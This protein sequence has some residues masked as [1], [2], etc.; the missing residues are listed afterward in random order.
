M[1]PQNK[2][3]FDLL[4]ITKFWAKGYTGKGIKIAE[5]E[6][7]LVNLPVFDGKLH[8]PF[9]QNAEST[10]NEHGQQVLEYIHNVAPDADLYELPNDGSFSATTAIGRFIEKTL[11]YIIDN[12]IDIVSSS[13]LGNDCIPVNNLIKKAQ[14]D[15]TIFVCSASNTGSSI[16]FN[17]FANNNLWMSIGACY[18]FSNGSY[19]R[20]SY[21]STGIELDFMSISNTYIL[22]PKDNT[23]GFRNGTS[24]STPIFSGMCALVQQF[25]YEKTGKKLNQEQMYHF[26]KDNCVDMDIA[27]RDDKTGYGLLILPDPD[28]IDVYKYIGDEPMDIKIDIKKGTIN[29]NGKDITLREKPQVINGRTMTP[30]RELFEALGAKVDWN[31]INEIASIK[32]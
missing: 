10:V 17:E 25:F 19:T 21:S 1:I 15:G 3:A 14:L 13:V 29:V 28:T 11:P 5:I 9:N 4:G 20:E 22:D 2:Q 7:S 18:L 32:K 8:D 26:V 27:S 24:F 23:I 16:G 30:I 6:R 31:A 12:K